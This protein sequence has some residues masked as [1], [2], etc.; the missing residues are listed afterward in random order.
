M[1]LIIVQR[2]FDEPADL[3]ALQA[4][5][6]AKAWCLEQ[7]QVTFRETLLALDRMRMICLYEAPDAEAV[8]HTQRTAG[9]PVRSVWVAQSHS[10]AIG[11]TPGTY[12]RDGHSLVVVE[13]IFEEPLTLESI[14]EMQA[15]T[16]GCL[17][18][19]DAYPVDTYLSPDRTETVCLFMAPDA[20]ALRKA[21]RVAGVPFRRVW[22]ATRH[23]AAARP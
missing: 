14:A 3:P 9:L 23:L 22:A 15:R 12:D 18:A 16:G 10:E 2:E 7:Y 19:H 20:E 11:R 5:E 8:R 6:D 21:N 17:Q 13:R 1:S 4:K